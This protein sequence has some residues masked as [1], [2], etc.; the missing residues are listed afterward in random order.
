MRRSLL[1]A[2]PFHRFLLQPSH[3]SGPRA[4]S[5]TSSSSRASEAVDEHAIFKYTFGRCII[6]ERDE[7]QKRYVKFNIPALKKA[8]VD[9]VD[10]A[11]SVVEF[12]RLMDAR[13]NR[14]IS[15]TMD[16]GQT[17]LA[18]LPYNNLVGPIEPIV[19]SEVATTEFASTKLG[20]P[21]PR[22]LGWCSRSEDTDVS[23]AYIIMEKV[24]GDPVVLVWEKLPFSQKC[25]ATDEIIEIQ[26]KMATFTSFPGYGSIYYRNY[27]KDTGYIPI[28]DTFVLGPAVT[29]P[30][31][32]EHRGKVDVTT[33]GPWTSIEKYL[34]SVINVEKHWIKEHAKPELLPSFQQY[35]DV[36]CD[37]AAH[38]ELLE[39]IEKLIP[40]ISLPQHVPRLARP[41]LWHP[42][43]S[44]GDIM[45]S[46]D[47]L[48]GKTSQMVSLI[49]WRNCLVGPLYLE[50]R[51]NAIYMNVLPGEHDANSSKFSDLPMVAEHHLKR[52]ATEEE[53]EECLYAM[54][55]KAM[56]LFQHI[57][58]GTFQ[59][60]NEKFME[61]RNAMLE[62]EELFTA[63]YIAT[64]FSS[65]TSLEERSRYR[66]EYKEWSKIQAGYELLCDKIG[67]N[68]EGWVEAVDYERT[69][70]IHT[71][72]H[73][74]WIS[75]GNSEDDWPFDVPESRPSDEAF[76]ELLNR[77]P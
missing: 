45:I 7:L 56:R 43:F 16:N 33:R 47:A 10:G 11:T 77:K 30:F 61:T 35:P 18:K 46:Y 54:S 9:A 4:I 26:R 20:L 68:T 25:Q 73:D 44:C 65:P 29:L 41:I 23:S 42:E 28:D 72:Y 51:S 52:L 74:E 37:P 39:R 62:L 64:S 31:T 14:M 58:Y 49:G 24:K 48:T 27:R 59:L 40:C 53:L 75:R 22:I 32:Y 12:R 36:I 8:A 63:E 17:V 50:V 38:I 19:E 13:Y 55:D 15:L 57:V 1:K 2:L 34:Q 6:N 5:T 66:E 60:W 70:L 76:K 71:S 21:V 3:R 69:R 67:V